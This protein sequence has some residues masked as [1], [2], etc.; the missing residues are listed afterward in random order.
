MIDKIVFS[1]PYAESDASIK[2]TDKFYKGMAQ[3]SET[4]PNIHKFSAEAQKRWQERRNANLPDNPNNIGN[5][6]Y[7]HI[8]REIS[9]KGGDAKMS[10]IK[11][12][13]DTAFR[14]QFFVPESFAHP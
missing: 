7:G 3:A 10:E 6:K 2:G 4:N 11:F 9:P 1:P 5:L 14:K 8:D 12:K 13:R